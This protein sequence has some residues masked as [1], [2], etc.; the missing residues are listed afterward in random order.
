MKFIFLIC[1]FYWRSGHMTLWYHSCF[2]LI[3]MVD[4]YY[5]QLVLHRHNSWLLVHHETMAD[6]KSVAY[7][8][9]WCTTDAQL[10]CTTDAQHPFLMYPF[11]VWCKMNAPYRTNQ[12]ITFVFILLF[13]VSLSIHWF[14]VMLFFTV[15][16]DAEQR[17]H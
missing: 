5:F 3:G 12:H 15:H 14:M 8:H 11:C 2:P 4:S 7:V 1:L 16:T 13:Q 6:F 10:M 17:I 9:N